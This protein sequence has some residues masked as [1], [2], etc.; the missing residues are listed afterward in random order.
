MEKIKILI[1]EDELLIAEDLR[2]QLIKLGYEV[3]DIASSYNEAIQSIMEDLPDLVMVDIQI[4]GPKDGIELGT[5]LHNEVEIPFI[6]LTSHSDR[7]TVSKAIQAHPNAYLVKPFKP[8]SLYTSIETAIVN[9][10]KK[11]QVEKD[12]IQNVDQDESEILLKDCFFIKKEHRYVKVKLSEIFYLV[13]DGNYVEV[14]TP[15]GKHIIRSTIK[16][17]SEQLPEKDFF[18]THKS[19]IA[20]L[21][22]IDAVATEEIEIAGT[23]I[24]LSKNRR[25]LLLKRMN[26][27]S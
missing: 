9:I 24:P 5:F 25:E 18:Q 27:F 6:F 20:N 8:D 2:L 21:H 15:T 16:S 11:G 4:D 19:Y 12:L 22:F 10:G 23:Q 13:S 14:V 17:L 1:V 3:T 7:S 26:T